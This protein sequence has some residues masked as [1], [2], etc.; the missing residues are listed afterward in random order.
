MNKELQKIFRNDQKDRR[1]P[2]ICNDAK[3][4][5]KNDKAR[6]K[7]VQE[8]ILSN[9]LS[10]AKDYYLAAMI[11]HHSPSIQDSMKAVK[12]SIT[13]HELGYKKALSF[14]AICL[15]RLLLKKGKKQKFGTQYHKKDSKSKWK[16]LPVD[17]K[18]TDEERKKYNIASLKELVSAMEKLNNESEPK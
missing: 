2:T 10:S 7:A 4:L 13:S 18:T 11:F 15:D 14:Y 17:P 3:L 6:R 8:L 9:K 5:T 12:L 16:L 1:N